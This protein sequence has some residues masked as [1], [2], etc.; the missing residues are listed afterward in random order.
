ML[1]CHPTP[2][3]GPQTADKHSRAWQGIVR[4]GFSAY[5]S[6]P[7]EEVVGAAARLAGN[8][9]AMADVSNGPQG[10]L[11]PADTYEAVTVEVSA[12]DGPLMLGEILS[13]HRRIVAAVLVVVALISFIPLRMVFSNPDTYVGLTQTLDT[14]I[15][16]VMGL[17][18]A[19]A[20]ASAGL[21]AIPGD[22]GTPIAE[23][24]IELAGNFG[25][26]LAIV[27]LEK[28]LLTIFG[29]AAFGL[30]VPVGCVL[31]IIAV[32]TYGRLTLSNVMAKLALKLV[33]LA[34]VLLCT[35]PTS[36]WVTN[37]ID[38][39]YQTSLVA[40]AAAEAAE[41]AAVADEAQ[42][43]ESEGAGNPID[44]LLG[45]FQGIPDAVASGLASVSDEILGQLNNLIEQFAVM[46]VTSC[47]IPVLVLV[48]YLWMA[49]L[50]LGINIE[51]PAAALKA[52]AT[53]LKTPPRRRSQ[54]EGITRAGRA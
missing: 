2:L 10:Q 1:F 54:G 48:F 49:N 41:D 35:I 29:T 51:A 47:L 31:G 4:E 9:G 45:F 21:S 20:A 11:E 38:E 8:G 46:I 40:S 17:T 53:S 42:Q 28:Y 14:K 18:A 44:S 27:F 22:A 33:V 24:L 16:N 39:T 12:G 32:M 43:G 36:V 37:T 7:N 23:K 34:A 13:R 15:D 50:L 26:I 6:G 3:K 5:Y 30:L 52:R 19:S 25:I